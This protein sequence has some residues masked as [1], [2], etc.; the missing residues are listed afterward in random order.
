M[1]KGKILLSLALLCSPFWLAAAQN[2]GTSQ[3]SSVASSASKISS[4]QSS[5]A[6]AVSQS[7][8]PP[9]SNLAP[10]SVAPKN[11]AQNPGSPTA[12]NSAPQSGSAA[13]SMLQ[14]LDDDNLG[15][16]NVTGKA[17]LLTTE[18]TGMYT[19]DNMNTATGLDLSIRQTP[20]TVSVV[21]DQLIK[22]LS[23]TKVD[24]ALNYVPGITATSR[25]GMSLP[26]SRGF[27]IDN[28]QEDGMQSTTAL[29]AQ[30]LYGQSKEH[31]DLAFYDRVEVLRG[32]AGLTQSNGEPGGTIN[33]VRKRPQ[34]ELGANLSL[35]AGSY[36]YY[37][38]SVD[39]TGGLNESGSLRGRLIGVSGK[40]GSFRDLQNTERGAASAM[41]GADLGDFSEILAGVIYQKT[42]SVYDPFGIPV[43]GKDGNALNLSKR[44]TFISDWSR[45]VYEKY[46]TFLELNHKFSDN[47]KAYAK[48]N[49]THSESLLKFG[50]WHGVG[51]DPASRYIGYDRYDNG[52]KEL[53]FQV[54]SDINY[55]LFGQSHD[56][57]INAT[58][59][60]E[61]FT[62]HDRDVYGGAAGLTYESF[63][64]G[65]INNEPNWN[66]TT[67]L[68]A[69]GTRCYNLYYTTKIYQ[70]MVAMG[71]RYNFND[72]WHLLVGGRY[73]RLKRESATD[74]YRTGRHSED[75]IVK[76]HK[77]T[78]YVG[79]TWDFSRDHS[80]Y[81]SYAEIY[82]PQTARDRNEKI[83]EPIVG[84][85]AEVGV[86]S[87][88]FDG[89]LN[90]TVAFFQI[91][92]ENR[93]VT[94]Y[95]YYDA[96][97]LSRSV[98]SGKVR[99]RG[100]DIEANGAIT[101]E[102]KVF[103]G[104]TYNKSEY[105]KDERRLAALSNVDYRKGAN[106]KPW[107]PKRMFK[108]YSS[109]EIPLVA[110]QKITLGAGFRY[111]SK[112][113][114]QYTRHN[115]STGAYYPANDIPVQGGYTIWDANAAYE[116]N[117][118]FSLNLSVKNITD[119]RYFINQNNRVAGQ[120]NYYGEPRN[121]MLTFNYKY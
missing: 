89:A 98:A 61:R 33:L 95:D 93:A 28:I 8:A 6:S 18:G 26:I 1:K 59:S 117:E 73:S 51:R 88:F 71:T 86:K 55:E 100:F 109:Y 39:V 57:F 52:S 21:P 9:V 37:R 36:D 35:S 4:S 53:S 99:S 87:E 70:Q 81:A 40:E 43:V 64:K 108:L 118:H 121:F 46:N 34:K 41:V 83:L 66:D 12:V 62:Q 31:T 5:R 112:T 84:Y 119:K 69:L 44:T 67:A 74:N 49:Y 115:I 42:R 27:N 58:A 103:G 2:S 111:Q 104:Y 120:N 20:Q 79:L 72:D 19:T 85:N 76:K 63:N 77:I 114:S 48:L 47:I 56:F 113:D 13:N 80:L 50:G 38:G 102:W 78:P 90:T 68:C 29:A 105:M 107:I 10:N 116:Y 65:L 23:L 30:G 54:G 3:N 22:D 11:S 92:Q 16:I 45:S 32:V 14:G 91:E 17:D 96:T 60:K 24:D 110:Q 101:D 97:G 94:D 7:S 82:K 15:T 75:D 25:F 106:A